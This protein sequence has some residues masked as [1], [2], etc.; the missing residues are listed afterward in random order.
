MEIKEG[1]K[2]RQK[3]MKERL[4]EILKGGRERGKSQPGLVMWT[5]FSDDSWR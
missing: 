2:N 5:R 3:E 4:K 1:K